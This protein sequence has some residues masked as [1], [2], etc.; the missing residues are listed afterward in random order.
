MEVF[1]LE[2]GQQQLDSGEEVFRDNFISRCMDDLLSPFTFGHSQCQLQL[3]SFSDAPLEYYSRGLLGRTTPFF[4]F[5]TD[6]LALYDATSFSHPI[7]ARLLLSTIDM[8]YAMDYRKL[9]FGDYCHILRTIKTRPDEVYSD[10][11]QRYLWPIETDLHMLGWY[12]RALLTQ[13]V[14]GFIRWL[15]LHHVAGNIW[16][17]IDKDRPTN[18]P[19]AMKLLSALATQGNDEAVKDIAMYTQPKLVICLPPNCFK[20]LASRLD[21]VQQIEDRRVRERLCAL[22][23]Q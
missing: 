11:L 22:L 18:V 17:D 3:P 13:S 14:E 5:Y 19:R 20:R 7:F 8:T 4:Q 2:H 16:T 12:L 10:D 15:A 21:Q 23:V 6:F 1:M 9:L